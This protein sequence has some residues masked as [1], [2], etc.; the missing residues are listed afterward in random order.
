MEDGKDC[1][2]V[3]DLLTTPCLCKVALKTYQKHSQYC[4]KSGE[5]VLISNDC[6]QVVAEWVSNML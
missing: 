4:L 1:E 2:V 6:Q 3:I 5:S